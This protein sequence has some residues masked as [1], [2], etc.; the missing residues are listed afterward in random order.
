M[1][2]N[3]ESTELWG[4]GSICFEVVKKTDWDIAKVWLTSEFECDDNELWD[5]L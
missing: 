2:E 1:W 5:I 3:F 4:A